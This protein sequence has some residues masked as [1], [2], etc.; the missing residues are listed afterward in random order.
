MPH[1]TCNAFFFLEGIMSTHLLHTLMQCVCMCVSYMIVDCWVCLASHEWRSVFIVNACVCA[2]VRVC[3]LFIA[4]CVIRMLFDDVNR[5][6]RIV[7]LRY[8]C[9]YCIR[10]RM[11]RRR[12]CFNFR[13]NKSHKFSHFNDLCAF[14]VLGTIKTTSV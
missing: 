10:T 12:W 14:R 5:F 6:V 1:A 8:K 7:P 9:Y 13:Y 3:S 2:T 4:S 11:D